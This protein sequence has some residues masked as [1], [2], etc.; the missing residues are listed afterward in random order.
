MSTAQALI[1]GGMIGFVVGSFL[2]M[3]L[4]IGL[5]LL[6]NGVEEALRERLELDKKGETKE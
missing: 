3:M 6:Q 5:G 4:G 1:V 2:W